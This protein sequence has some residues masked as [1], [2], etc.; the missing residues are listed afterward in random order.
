MRS[1]TPTSPCWRPSSTPTISAPAFYSS[2]NYDEAVFADPFVFD[3]G[4]AP[5]PHLGFGGGGPHFCLGRHLA[6]LEV[7]VMLRTLIEKVHRV[8]PTG[9]V[10]RLRSNFINGII[11][12]PVRLTPP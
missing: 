9:P 2:A 5:N 10:R 11:E 1:R 6:M 3:I 8:E 4:R 12:L 7:E